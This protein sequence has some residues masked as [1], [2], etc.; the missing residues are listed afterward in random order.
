M[1]SAAGSQT[2]N[3]GGS[4]FSIEDAGVLSQAERIKV[5]AMTLIVVKVFIVNISFCGLLVG[6]CE[7]L[8]SFL[9]WISY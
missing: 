2:A 1:T 8:T 5:T 7:A 6:E 4:N 9:V 3:D